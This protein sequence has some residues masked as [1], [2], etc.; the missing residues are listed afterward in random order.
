M[1]SEVFTTINH[2]AQVFS[3]NLDNSND[4]HVPAPSNIDNVG[5]DYTKHTHIISTDDTYGIDGW[6]ALSTQFD[7]KAEDT[8]IEW[9]MEDIETL[10]NGTK[11]LIVSD[12]NSLTI[13]YLPPLCLGR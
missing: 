5:K 1:I 8:Q 12:V 6:I 10:I 3:Q 13:F 9:N 11:A 7:I 4:V 2:M